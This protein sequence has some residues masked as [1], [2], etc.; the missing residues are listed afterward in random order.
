MIDPLTF[1]VVIICKTAQHLIACFLVLMI[2]SIA[3]NRK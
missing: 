2:F 1:I 3:I